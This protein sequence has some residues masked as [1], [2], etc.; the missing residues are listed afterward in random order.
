MPTNDYDVPLGQPPI[1]N[2]ELN[3]NSTRYDHLVAA[4]SDT[5]L[6]RMWILWSTLQIIVVIFVASVFT[7]VLVSRRA[8]R[9]PFNIYLIF[10]FLPDLFYCAACT[11]TCVLNA[12]V[13]HYYSPQMCQF[14][15]F[16]L[17]F[18]TCANS[19]LNAAICRQLHLMLRSSHVR[20]KYMVPSRT[21]IAKEACIVYLWACFVASWALIGRGFFPHRTGS[22]IGTAC[23]PLEYDFDSSM[24]F[25]LFF[26]PCLALIPQFYV[27]YVSFDIWN[28]GLLPP[29]GKRRILAIYF[30]RIVAVF[31]VM[32][33][34]V[35]FLTWVGTNW[36]G[37]WVFWFAGSW[38]HLQAAVSAAFSLCKPDIWKAYKSILTCR[39]QIERNSGSDSTVSSWLR[40][41]SIRLFQTEGISDDVGPFSS[42][43]PKQDTNFQY[44]DELIDTEPPLQQEVVVDPPILQQPE[45]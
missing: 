44:E 41:M 16:Y 1:R 42:A 29:V 32:W 19:W 21:K 33:L 37:P 24:F 23:M 40:R 25:F 6:R 13:G 7:A 17:V 43:L 18:A 36:A 2:W 3:S 8:R 9:N 39:V 22:V 31:V 26:M 35:L 28:R 15:S 10:L 45:P 27:A 20:R 5:D 34:P 14:Q 38:S 12:A 11:I 30:I 4:P